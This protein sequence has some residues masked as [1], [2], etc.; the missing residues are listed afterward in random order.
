MRSNTFLTFCAAA[1]CLGLAGCAADGSNLLTT[2]SVTPAKKEVVAAVD[3]AC[4]ALQNRIDI[5]REEGTIGRVEKAASGKTKTVVIKRE[6]LGKVAEFN[7]ANAEFRQRCSNLPKQ[8][9][10]A[11]AAP[12][13]AVPATTAAVKPKPAVPQAAVTPV[14][15]RTA[16]S[17]AATTTRQ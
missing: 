2:A 11:V 7:Q 3:P 15:A 9:T 6:A 17:Q 14:Q 5:L 13:P 10:A 1:T 12:K 16:A 4:L 8:Q